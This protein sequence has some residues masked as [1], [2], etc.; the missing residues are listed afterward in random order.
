MSGF[1]SPTSFMTASSPA[2]T[3]LTKDDG[4]LTK[5]KPTPQTP[6]EKFLA[7]AKMTP[8]EKLRDAIL[9]SIG[10]TEEELKNMSPKERE[11]IENKIKE[12]IKEAAENQT[13]KKTGFITDISA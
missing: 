11:A 1:I 8:A 4:S 9:K 10:V 3:R 5:S 13:D 2:S 6:E 12:K 7:Y